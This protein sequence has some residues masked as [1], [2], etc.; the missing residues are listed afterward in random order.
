MIT[1]MQMKDTVTLTQQQ[2]LN[3]IVILQSNHRN[4]LPVY[5]KSTIMKMI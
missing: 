1:E 5:K 3:I 4:F 2:I